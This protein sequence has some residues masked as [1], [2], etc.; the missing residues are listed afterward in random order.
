MRAWGIVVAAGAG[1]RAGSGTPKS[2]RPLAGVPMFVHA[3]RALQDAVEGIVVVVPS[4][5]NDDALEKTLS[6]RYRVPVQLTHGGETRA[7]SVAAGLATVP[8]DAEAIVVH[9]AA[10][11]LASPELAHR[12][13]DALRDADGA[14]CAVPVA[15]TIKRVDGDAIVA[16][17]DRATLRR[18]QTP[19]AFRAQILRR[20]HADGDRN[21]TDDA[22]L[23][24]ALGG[25]VV[26]VEGDERNIKVTTAEDL[27]LAERMLEGP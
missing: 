3:M 18:A 16:T 10:R 20:A 4:G 6:Y 9:D 19:Q 17:V 11:P 27:V 2:L 23:V 25:R 22:A 7:A 12:V 14:V 5:W 1:V 21:A 15:D 26:I 24:E 8:A 13:L